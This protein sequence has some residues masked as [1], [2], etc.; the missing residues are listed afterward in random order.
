MTREEAATADAD[1]EAFLE[2]ARREAEEEERARLAKAREAERRRKEFSMDPWA[3]R[4][5]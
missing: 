2:R 1:Y 4:A 5:G 3:G